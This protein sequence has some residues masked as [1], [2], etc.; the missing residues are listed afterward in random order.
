M[1]DSAFRPGSDEEWTALMRQL[2]RQPQAQPQPFFYARV[3]A[4]LQA[5]ADSPQG[6]WLPAWLWRPAYVA[7]LSAMVVVVNGDGPV[8]APTHPSHYPAYQ[9]P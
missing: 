5:Q 3:R 8:A 9:L 2:Q 1:P 6:S 4:R 7:V